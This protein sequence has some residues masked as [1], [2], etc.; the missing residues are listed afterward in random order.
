MP[1]H[2]FLSRQFEGIRIQVALT[3][4]PC[5]AYLFDFVNEFC[6]MPLLSRFL[7]SFFS[8]FFDGKVSRKAITQVKA[9]TQS[10]YSKQMPKI[11]PR[12]P[13]KKTVLPP[14][15]ELRLQ[16]ALSLFFVLASLVWQS[17]GGSSRREEAV[18]HT[19]T[20]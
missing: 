14:V 6:Q 7:F 16:H 10:C 20:F 3:R 2:K 15:K 9:A 12:R 1:L 17:Q 4:G 18:A 5:A 13:A 11:A 8:F 19:A